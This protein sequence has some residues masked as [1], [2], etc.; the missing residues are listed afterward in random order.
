MIVTVTKTIGIAAARYDR[1]MTFPKQSFGLR[2]HNIHLSQISMPGRFRN[3][4]RCDEF[5][6][7]RPRIRA[8]NGVLEEI[9][10]AVSRAWRNRHRLL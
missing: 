1:T 6:A 5:V 9:S 7:L 2:T 10:G 4:L 3:R 8:K